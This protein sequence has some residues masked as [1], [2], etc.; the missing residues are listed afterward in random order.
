MIEFCYHIFLICSELK[1]FVFI[2]S[3]LVLMYIFL[4]VSFVKTTYYSY[5]VTF[6][7]IPDQYITV[8]IIYHTF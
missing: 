2:I 5:A 4:N 6:Y 8:L 1:L 7:I 3:L